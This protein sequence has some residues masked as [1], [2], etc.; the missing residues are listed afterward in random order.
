MAKRLMVLVGMLMALLVAAVPA[1]AQGVLPPGGVTVTGVL[2]S[3]PNDGGPPVFGI[4]D[5][6]SGDRYILEGDGSDIARLEGQRTYVEGVPRNDPN[7]GFDFLEVYGYTAA[8]RAG[9]PPGEDTATLSFELTVKG[10]PPEGARFFGSAVGEGGPGVPLTDPDDD[11]IFTGSV[12]VPKF[13]PGLRPV[14]PGTPPI[15]LSVRIVQVEQGPFGP[16]EPSVIKDFGVVPLDGDKAFR[17]KVNFKKGPVSPEEP[18]DECLA[19]SLKPEEC[20]AYVGPG[21]GGSG[22]SGGSGSGGSGSGNSGPGISGSGYGNGASVSG[23]GSGGSEIK[24]SGK[25]SGGGT[26]EL[27][28]TGGAIPALSLVGTLLVG[29]GLLIR[30]ATR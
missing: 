8:D 11:G 18:T 17:A 1:M 19:L 15:A 4:T 26:K 16:G 5:E 9:P 27:P 7:T 30:R 10:T 20:E 12:T 24:A 28:R 13:P 23:S 25:S 14:P 3:L 29:G 2:E 22:G 21:G 6:A